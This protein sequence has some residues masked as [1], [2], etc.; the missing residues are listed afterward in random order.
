MVADEC[1]IAVAPPALISCVW[2]VPS[3]PVSSTTTRHLIQLSSSAET[4]SPHSTPRFETVSNLNRERHVRSGPCRSGAL[5][6]AA[7]SSCGVSTPQ[8]LDGLAGVHIA[9]GGDQA[10][11][12]RALSLQRDTHQAAVAFGGRGRISGKRTSILSGRS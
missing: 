1:S 3:R 7:V 12:D 6:P 4:N 8:V 10:L 2:T 5:G 9:V 11:C